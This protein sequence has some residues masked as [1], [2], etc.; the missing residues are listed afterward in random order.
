MCLRLLPRYLLLLIWG[1]L[2]VFFLYVALFTFFN[3]FFEWRPDKISGTLLVTLMIS[4]NQALFGL[5]GT[6]LF[7]ALAKRCKWIFCAYWASFAITMLWLVFVISPSSKDIPG[8]FGCGA[9]LTIIGVIIQWKRKWL[10]FSS[11]T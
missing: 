2:A 10:G 5:L 1:G 9:F 8:I 7:V 4:G 11:G 6:V 3:Y